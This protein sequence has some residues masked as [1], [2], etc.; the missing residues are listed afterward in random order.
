MGTSGK[1]ERVDVL[2]T[3]ALVLASKEDLFKSTSIKALTRR[4]PQRNLWPLVVRD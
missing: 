1:Q 3:T 4:E 2:L